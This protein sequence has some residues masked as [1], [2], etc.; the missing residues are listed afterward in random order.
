MPPVPF[1]KQFDPMKEN[2]YPPEMV[3]QNQ[4]ALALTDSQKTAVKETMLKSMTKFTE[5][6]WQQ[7]A[8]QENMELLLKQER[9]DEAKV[10]A[11]LDKLLGVEDDMKRAMFGSLLK[12]RN[13]LTPAQLAKLR[14]IRQ[15]M[16]SPHQH[17][18]KG[19]KQSERQS[20]S[21]PGK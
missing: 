10:L 2:L 20:E 8:E 18:G 14:A 17:G 3:M 19:E 1:G 6:M 16:T 13:I 5:L 15:T 21:E 11:Q 12:V 7:S 4:R 9:L